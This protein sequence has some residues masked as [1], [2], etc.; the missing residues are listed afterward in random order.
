MPEKSGMAAALCSTVS[1]RPTA[2][3][4]CCPRAGA[5]PAANITANVT[6]KSKLRCTFMSTSLHELLGTC[7][8]SS[9]DGRGRY[10]IPNAGT[11]HACPE[12]G[13]RGRQPAKSSRGCRGL[14][15]D[16]HLAALDEIDRRAED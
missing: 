16:L 1:A 10:L 4:A 14:R 15:T 5:P 13:G 2:G 11:A 3:G 6:N 8:P 12:G 9:R 7:R